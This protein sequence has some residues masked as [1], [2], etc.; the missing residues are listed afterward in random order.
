[1]T[2]KE[3]DRFHVMKLIKDKRLTLK[4]MG[5]SVRQT[6]RIWKR[7][8]TKGKKGIISK[9]RGQAAGNKISHEMRNKIAEN[10]WIPK[11]KKTLSH[12]H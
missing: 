9:R 1:M 6:I 8:K 12:L 5:I 7:F 11:R 4:Q 2:A 3:V 10:L